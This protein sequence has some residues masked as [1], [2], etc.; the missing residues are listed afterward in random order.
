MNI[1]Y[2]L[3][4]PVSGGKSGLL[5]ELAEEVGYCHK[6][7]FIYPMGTTSL[8]VSLGPLFLLVTPLSELT[9]PSPKLRLFGTFSIRIQVSECTL[10]DCS[11]VLN[12]LQSTCFSPQLT[13]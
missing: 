2:F 8:I 9:E 7:S 4:K 6:R 1:D 3:S 12:T 10:W 13:G 11:V 5:K